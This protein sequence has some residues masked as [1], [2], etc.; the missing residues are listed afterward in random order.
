[1]ITLWKIK[2]I[3]STFCILSYFVIQLNE[4]LYYKWLR[5]ENKTDKQEEVIYVD[6]K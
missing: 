5:N 3:R 2:M 4:F 6:L 1:V